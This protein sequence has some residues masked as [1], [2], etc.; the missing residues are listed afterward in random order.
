M[1]EEH[2]PGSAIPLLKQAIAMDSQ[3]VE[4]NYQLGRS[5]RQAGRLTEAQVYFEKAIVIDPT[6]KLHTT[7]LLRCCGRRTREIRG[8]VP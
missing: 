8:L 1:L 4:A 5:L 6:L 3:N 2:S 7:L